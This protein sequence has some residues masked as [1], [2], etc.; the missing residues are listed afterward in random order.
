MSDS[1]ER[2]REEFEK[3]AVE[4]RRDFLLNPQTRTAKLIRA[5]ALAAW[6]A[7]ASIYIERADRIV[8]KICQ[9]NCI[10]C[11]S[12]PNC[13]L[14]DAQEICEELRALKPAEER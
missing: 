14:K 7:S 8:Q 12:R 1:T 11:S 10:E 2:M 13:H 9:A 3:W 5:V 6:R 4:D